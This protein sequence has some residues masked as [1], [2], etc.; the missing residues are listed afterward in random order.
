MKY[1]NINKQKLRRKEK[2]LK[3]D[4][5]ISTVISENKD[6]INYCYHKHLK[7]LLYYL[8]IIITIYILEILFFKISIV[9]IDIFILYLSICLLLYSCLYLIFY[10]SKRS[11]KDWKLLNTFST[12]LSIINNEVYRKVFYSSITITS[13]LFT[14]YITMSR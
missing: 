13:I 8:I 14:L 10:L 11:I 5:L 1:N 9:S 12:N 3:V 7:I 4:K 6:I 2:E